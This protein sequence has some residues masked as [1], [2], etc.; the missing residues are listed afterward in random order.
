MINNII[1][2]IRDRDYCSII[3]IKE[4]ACESFYLDEETQECRLGTLSFA[5]RVKRGGKTTNNKN[6]MNTTFYSKQGKYNYFMTIWCL[7]PPRI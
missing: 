7:L 1:W 4:N 3:C 6:F 5:T 2:N